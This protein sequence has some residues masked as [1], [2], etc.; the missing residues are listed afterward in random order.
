[1]TRM[2]DGATTEDYRLALG[3]LPDQIGVF[4]TLSYEWA[5]KPHRL[6]YDLCGEVDMLRDCLASIKAHVEPHAETSALA[7]AVVATCN[8]G[9]LNG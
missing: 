9:L 7:K 2:R 6:V 8:I 3:A 4:G 1:M 5:D